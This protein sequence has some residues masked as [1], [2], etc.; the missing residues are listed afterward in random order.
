MNSTTHISLAVGFAMALLLGTS[1][2]TS[3][4]VPTSSKVIPAPIPVTTSVEKTADD[5]D[6]RRAL[7]LENCSACHGV[8]GYGDGPAAVAFCLP[9][10]DLTRIAELNGGDFPYQEIFAV[11]EGKRQIDAHGYRGMPIWGD[12]F[13]QTAQNAGVGDSQNI[14]DGNILA[15]VAY[16]ESIQTYPVEEN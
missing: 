9:P 16:L 10:P 14:A 11:I 12:L 6:P 1:C 4:V 2:Q 13:K 8:E 7:Y 3:K 15:L 5:K